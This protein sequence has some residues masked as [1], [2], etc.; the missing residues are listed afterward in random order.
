[1]AAATTSPIQVG[2]KHNPTA[3]R[4]R[5]HR[6]VVAVQP[7][8]VIAGN[9]SSCR[10]P[11]TGGT[12]GKPSIACRPERS[13]ARRIWRRASAL[14]CQICEVEVFR[15]AATWRAADGPPALPNQQDWRV[16][17]WQGPR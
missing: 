9:R 13:A 16:R 4:G 11:A 15:H 1:M 7:H 14:T 2:R 17:R 6:I 8:I 5:M 10:Q 3:N 12:G